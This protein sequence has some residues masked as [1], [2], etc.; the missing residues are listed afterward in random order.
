MSL[1]WTPIIVNG[2]ISGIV[3][4]EDANPLPGAQIAIG[5]LNTSSD[6]SGFYSFS[7]PPGSYNLS[8]TAAGYQNYYLNDI[9]VSS[10]QTTT[11]NIPMATVGNH[12]LADSVPAAV[13]SPVYPNP[14]R[15]HAKFR[16]YSP[17][18]QAYKLQVFNSKG[19]LVYH[20]EGASKGGWQ[21]IIWN[22]KDS[23]GRACTS[24][25]YH[26]KLHY[27]DQVLL[28]KFSLMR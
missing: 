15:N 20:K 10:D 28:Q 22:G 1:T 3:S 8:C 9:T 11:V 16:F 24:G 27:Q 4:D 2:T 6:N 26:A 5:A 14:G 13:F 18:Q 23:G 12:D 7:V 25:I 19:Q 21:E 17:S